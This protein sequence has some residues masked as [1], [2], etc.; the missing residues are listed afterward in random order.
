MKT[1]MN[2]L[3]VVGFF[4][5]WMLFASVTKTHSAGEQMLAL[6]ASLIPNV[7]LWTAF[8]GAASDVIDD[9]RKKRWK[10]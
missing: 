6:L 3:V 4:T 9:W 7:I 2:L 5:T 8:A 1:V 10:K